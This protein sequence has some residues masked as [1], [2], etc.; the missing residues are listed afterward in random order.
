MIEFGHGFA[1]GGR[2][3]D[4]AEVFRPDAF[5]EVAQTEL[6]GRGLDFLRY[7]DFL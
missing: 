6:F 5:N 2:A 3:D 7:G 1:F 4:Y